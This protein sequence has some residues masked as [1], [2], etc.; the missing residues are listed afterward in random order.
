MC[1]D[2]TK[3][4]DVERLMDG[5]KADMVFTDPPYGVSI[6]SKTTATVGGGGKTHFKGKV[7]GGNLVPATVYSEVIGDNTTDASREHIKLCKELDIKRFIIWGGNYFTDFLN[8]SR[9]WLVWNKKYEEHKSN[10]FADVELAWTN[11]DR[12]AKIYNCL[13]RGLLKEGE[14][15]KRQHPTQKPIKVLYE[16]LLDFTVD[17]EIIFDGFLGS[18]STLIACEKTNRICYGM[19][20]DPKYCDVIIKRYEDYTGNKAV[21]TA[22]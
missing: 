10:T 11:Y 21:K 2:S 6:V 3:R 4:E 20:L 9:C 17:D 14:H 13:W 1:G 7:G 16:I 15:G 19:E 12:N 22:N 18:G 8:K 5:K